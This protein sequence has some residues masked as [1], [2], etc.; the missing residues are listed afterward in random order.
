MAH[1]DES[2]VPPTHKVLS[3]RTKWQYYQPTY[4]RHSKVD[5]AKAVPETNAEDATD[6]RLA[7]AI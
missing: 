3:P 4:P 2:D 5:D 6:N 1:V 7:N